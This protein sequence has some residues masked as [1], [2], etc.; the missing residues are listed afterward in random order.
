MQWTKPDFQEICPDY[1][2]AEKT[3]REFVRTH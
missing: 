3:L 2:T 1:A